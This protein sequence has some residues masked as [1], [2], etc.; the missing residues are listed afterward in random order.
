MGYLQGRDVEFGRCKLSQNLAL[1]A[2]VGAT[3]QTEPFGLG[4]TPFSF[5][6]VTTA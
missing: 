1:L 3:Y 4:V 6:P 5:S 2:S